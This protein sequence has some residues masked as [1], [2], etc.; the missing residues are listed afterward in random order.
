[1]IDT[2]HLILGGFSGGLVGFTLG[3]VGGGGS[4]LAGPLMVYLVGVKNPHVA[5]GTSALA[6]ALNAALGLASHARQGM[7]NG[8]AG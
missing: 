7:S 3:V 8:V 4:I 2:L 1:M 6:V 5:I